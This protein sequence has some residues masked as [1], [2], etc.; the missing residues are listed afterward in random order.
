[1]A[2]LRDYDYF[3]NKDSYKS[4]QHTLTDEDVGKHFYL[5]QNIKQHV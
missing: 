2:H 5:Y 3:I 4:Q 1:M